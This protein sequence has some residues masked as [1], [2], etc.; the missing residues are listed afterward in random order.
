MACSEP[1]GGGALVFP[2]SAVTCFEFR[3]LGFRVEG[4]YGWFGSG[5]QRT[6][7]KRVHN[8]VV[9]GA[10]S[11]RVSGFQRSMCH[12]GPT[13]GL[14]NSIGLFR[15]AERCKSLIEPFFDTFVKPLQSLGRACLPDQY[16]SHR[17]GSFRKLGVPYSWG[18][19]KRILLFRVLH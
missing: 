14:H 9:T 10:A 16:L 7:R 13:L 12:V 8:D 4:G 11:G 3:G 1:C 17:C 6:N 5:G 15:E 19:L 2:K 18:L